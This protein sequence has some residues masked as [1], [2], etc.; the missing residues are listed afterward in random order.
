MFRHSRITVA[1]GSVE[2]PADRGD[3]SR[4]TAYTLHPIEDPSP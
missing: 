2:F 3:A 1:L 4:K